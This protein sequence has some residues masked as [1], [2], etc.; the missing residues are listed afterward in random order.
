MHSPGISVH[1]ITEN[2]ESLVGRSPCLY[3]KCYIQ[4]AIGHTTLEIA[5]VETR[6]SHYFESYFYE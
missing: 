6:Y 1:L 4:A 2:E 5:D 3:V